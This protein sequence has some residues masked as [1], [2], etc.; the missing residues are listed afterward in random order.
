VK[1]VDDASKDRNGIADT[2]M[3]AIVGEMAKT[4]AYPPSDDKQ[5]IIED[6]KLPETTRK[7]RE[8]VLEGKKR[9]EESTNEAKGYWK[10]IKKIQKKLGV[11]PQEARGIYETQRGLRMFETVKPSLT[12]VGK[13]L[14]NVLISA[15]LGNNSGGKP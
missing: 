9:A 5:F 8:L 1:S 11:T 14:A 13:D 6:I 2:V 12:L 4:G 7:L 10:A 3:Q 15:N